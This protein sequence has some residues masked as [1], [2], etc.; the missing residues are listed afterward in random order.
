MF[1]SG[2]EAAAMTVR[3]VAFV[4]PEPRILGAATGVVIRPAF[5]RR[6]SAQMVYIEV[7]EAPERAGSGPVPRPQ[8]GSQRIDT[9]ER[10][11]AAVDAVD[12]GHE[13]DVNR[14]RRITA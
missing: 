12:A 14:K 7:V 4:R 11:H 3:V 1:V 10:R 6:Y 13:H 9:H 2:S 5:L 8:S